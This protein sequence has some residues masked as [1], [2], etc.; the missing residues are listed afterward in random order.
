MLSPMTGQLSGRRHLPVLEIASFILTINA[1]VVFVLFADLQE[2]YGLT[3]TDVGLIA[4][5]G[6]VSALVV[7]LGFAPLADRGKVVEVG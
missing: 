3:D 2:A 6:F 5:A 7:T 1:G 4:S